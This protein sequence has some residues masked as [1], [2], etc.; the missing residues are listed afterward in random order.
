MPPVCVSDAFAVVKTLIESEKPNP[1]KT[2]DVNE[3]STD[4]RLDLLDWFN[5]LSPFTYSDHNCQGGHYSEDLAP[6]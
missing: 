5:V 2:G 3:G 1:A 4:L 6:S